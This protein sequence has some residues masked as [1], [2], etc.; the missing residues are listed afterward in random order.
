MFSVND[1]RTPSIRIGKPFVDYAL[2]IG[3]F[4]FQ[5]QTAFG[6]S[7][8][9]PS[10]IQSLSPFEVLQLDGQVAPANGMLSMG[11]ITP[12]EWLNGDPGGTGFRSVII[13][14][15]GGAKGIGSK[16]Y[17]HGG[18]HND[19]ANNGLYIYDFGGSDR[20]AGWD[21]PLVISSV[22][23]VTA[24]SATYADGLPN[25]VHTYDGMV[26]AHHNGTVYRFGGSRYLS[27]YLETSSFKFNESAGGWTRLPD[28]PGAAGG[29]HTIY[30]AASGNIFVTGNDTT[31]GHIFRTASET[32]SGQI[33][34]GG[35]GFP[36]NSMGAWDSTRG[37]GIVVGEN[38]TS[39]I[40]I[41]FASETVDVTSFSP[42]GDTGIF[43]E[44]AIS[45]VYDPAVD[46][47]WLFGG[48][49]NSVG[50]GR[51]YQMN[52]DGPP[53]N[54]T[55]ASLSGDSI[56]RSANMWGSYGRYILMPGWRAIGLVANEDSP[57]SIIRLPGELIP[58]PKPP[59]DLEGQSN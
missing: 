57:P 30:D 16:L 33:G 31:V 5:A 8:P 27:G 35:N 49:T 58:P 59:G 22:G 24:E 46:A 11:D 50:W 52:A 36:F 18:G 17:V 6:Q 19:S 12:S 29:P 45:A 13:A 51:I 55:S 32:W 37:R 15:N 48:S 54:V 39:L 56:V 47:Y 44:P 34:Y 20:P 21:T 25:S 3:I 2:L 53:W 26:Y 10:Y 40:T 43:G 41:N 28:Y 1:R 23:A 9:V 14:W 42:S 38:E 7:G 4:L